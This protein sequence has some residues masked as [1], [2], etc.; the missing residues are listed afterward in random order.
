MAPLLP[1]LPV[2]PLLCI[3]LLTT[4]SLFLPLPADSCVC[5]ATRGS[6]SC[7]HL[8]TFRAACMLYAFP[9]VCSL[10]MRAYAVG[11][12]YTPGQTWCSSDA[13]VLL[14]KQCG[15]WF[16]CGLHA[17][18]ATCLLAAGSMYT[19]LHTHIR[20]DIVLLWRC[21]AGDPDW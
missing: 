9:A 12:L 20:S 15:Y 16:A 14:I 17:F 8:C 2:L 6:L 4:S 7:A 18:T 21:Y 1:V 3:F 19:Q 5:L 11:S 10:T 13:S